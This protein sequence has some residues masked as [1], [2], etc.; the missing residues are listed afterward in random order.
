MGDSMQKLLWI[1]LTILA[2][3]GSSTAKGE[4]IKPFELRSIDEA[5][6]Y[7]GKV[8]Y[9]LDDISTTNKTLIAAIGGLMAIGIHSHG[10]AWLYYS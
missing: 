9:V 8:V 7:S 2:I 4:D 3:W 6:S 10:V 1:V 5:R